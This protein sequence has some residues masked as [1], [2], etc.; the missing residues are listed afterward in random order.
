MIHG[1]FVVANKFPYSTSHKIDKNKL[2]E[3]YLIEQTN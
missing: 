1:D 3:N 2:I